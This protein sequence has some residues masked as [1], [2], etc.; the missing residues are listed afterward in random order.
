MIKL[1]NG[2]IN[3]GLFG[4]GYWGRIYL[5]VLS[6]ISNVKVKFVCDTDP[7]KKSGAPKGLNFFYDPE[8]AIDNSSIDAAFVVTPPATH[9]R[10]ASLVLK[11]GIDVFV[12]KPAT[13]SLRDLDD[14]VAVKPR[15]VFFYPGHI[16]AYNDLVKSFTT[17][18]LETNENVVSITSSRKAFGPIRND[19]G[20]LWD[21]YPHDL[22]IFDLLKVGSPE[23][24]RCI[25][26]DIFNTGREDYAHC[27]IRYSSGAI[28]SSELSWLYPLKT[29]QTSVLMD[30]S[31]GLFDEMNA[32]MPI[33]I[34]RGRT[35]ILQEANRIAN[36][37]NTAKNYLKGIKSI[38]GEPLKNMILAF[39]LSVKERTSEFAD[40]ELER[41]RM[42]ISVLEAAS[43][44]MEKDGE[45]EYIYPHR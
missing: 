11:K 34:F 30:K 23:Y 20:C 40:A 14:V 1:P 7:S 24:V 16:Y 37:G 10:I 2:Q 17:S 28:A 9:K 31:I 13:I 45:K 26:D 19:V 44:S 39:L 29:R 8:Q 15:E 6:E 38:N 35:N 4:F 21:L 41:S 33:S 25:G 3:I 18:I 36:G 43:K 42:I 22:T 12:E 32:E 5:R 27:H